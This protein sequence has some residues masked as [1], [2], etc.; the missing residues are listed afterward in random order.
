MYIIV[1]I[2]LSKQSCQVYTLYKLNIYTWWLTFQAATC[3][4]FAVMFLLHNFNPRANLWIQGAN[5]KTTVYKYDNFED[6]SKSDKNVE[7]VLLVVLLDTSFG[8]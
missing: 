5:C 6:F 4:V 7:F 3:A 1:Y 8:E 2:N